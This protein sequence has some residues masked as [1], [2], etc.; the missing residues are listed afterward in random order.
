M[1]LQGADVEADAVLIDGRGGDLANGR[2]DCCLGCLARS[3]QIEVARR[4]VRFSDPDREQHG[5]LQDELV[6][7]T[8][9]R[10]AEQE[11]LSR[12]VHERQREVLAALLGDLQEPGPDGRRDVDRSLSLH[13]AIASQYGRITRVI[14]SRSACRHSSSTVPFRRRR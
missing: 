1:D 6:P 12:V 2:F 4:S 7:A 3:E 13:D 10:Q 11:A 9:T 14:R 5:A 8:R